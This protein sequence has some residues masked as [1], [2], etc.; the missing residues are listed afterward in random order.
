MVGQGTNSSRKSR[1]DTF[2][3][4]IN[5]PGRCPERACPAPKLGQRLAVS[6]SQL[7][8]FEFHQPRNEKSTVVAPAFVMN[9]STFRSNPLST[10]LAVI[11]ATLLL[12]SLG[13]IHLR[14]LPLPEALGWLP[15]GTY[16][17]GLLFCLIAMA[18]AGLR[19][20]LGKTRSSAAQFIWCVA[21]LLIYGMLFIY[22]LPR[23]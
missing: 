10:S 8:C 19:L 5:E 1:D 16:W 22:E 7:G 11:S 9:A 15:G 6:E 3:Q 14:I 4:S 20:R 21:L 12:L 17:V 13:E 23:R 2:R 18:I